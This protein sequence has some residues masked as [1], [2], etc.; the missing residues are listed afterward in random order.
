M[1][2]RNFLLFLVICSIS[3]N[4]L[5]AWTNSDSNWKLCYEENEIKKPNHNEKLNSYDP[6]QSGESNVDAVCKDIEVFLDINGEASI[7]PDMV[8]NGSTS[9]TNQNLSLSISTFNC[10]NLGQNLVTL[11]VSCDEGDDS[12]QATVDVIDNVFPL[13]EC[14]SH[15][16]FVDNTGFV[17]VDYMD[18]ISN[19]IDNCQNAV[20]SLSKD[21]LFCSDQSSSTITVTGTD[22]GGASSCMSTVIIKD[23]VKPDAFCKDTVFVSLGA[24]GLFTLDEV[25]V[26]D[27]STDNCS[28]TS[29]SLSIYELNCNDLGFSSQTMTVVDNSIPANSDICDFTLS[30]SNGSVPQMVCSNATVSLSQDGDLTVDPSLV[31]GGSTV[32]CGAIS[33]SLDQEQFGC[34]NLGPNLVVLT[35]E[36]SAGSTSSTCNAVITV[37][38]N[39]SPNL[40]CYANVTVDLGED[41]NLLLQAEDLIESI[42]DNCSGSFVFDLD[43]DSFDCTDLGNTFSIELVALDDENNSAICTSTVSID[44]NSPPML[45][46]NNMVATITSEEGVSILSADLVGTISDNCD[47]DPIISPV[48]FDFTCS[49]TN[50]N[51]V[52]ITATDNNGNVSTCSSVININVADAPNAECKPNLTVELDSDGEG[53]ISVPEVNDGSSVLCQIP[54]MTLDQDIFTC[55][56]LLNSPVSVTLIVSNS[57]G[58]TDECQTLVTVIDLEEPEVTCKPGLQEVE[59]DASGVASGSYNEF[60]DSVN[61]NCGDVNL[62]VET[63][64][65]QCTDGFIPYNIFVEDASNNSNSCTTLIQVVDNLLPTAV[66]NSVTVSLNSVGLGT[67]QG[68]DLTAGSFDNCSV[69][70]S[71]DAFTFDCGDVGQDVPVD[72]TVFDGSGNV[73]LPCTAMVTV[74]D[75]HI[76]T[77]ICNEDVEIFVD[78]NNLAVLDPVSL[79]NNSYDNCSSADLSFSVSQTNFNCDFLGNNEVTLYVTDPSNNVDTCNATI[80]VSDNSNPIAQCLDTTF[81]ALNA[82]GNLELVLSDIFSGS[83]FS[84]SGFNHSIFP[85]SFDCTHVGIVQEVTLSIIGSE[86]STAVCNV[87]IQDLTPPTF[88][89]LDVEVVLSSSAD[90]IIEPEA[91]I[92]NGSDVCTGTEIYFNISPLVVNCDNIGETVFEL[93]VIDGNLNVDSCEVSITVEN[94]TLPNAICKATHEVFLDEEGDASIEIDD[95]NNGS[96][97]LCGNILPTTGAVL[98][99]TQF[100]CDD[101]DVDEVTLFISD[102][103]GNVDSCTTIILVSDTIPPEIQDSFNDTIVFTISGENEILS[104]NIYDINPIDN[105]PILGTKIRRINDPM[106]LMDFSTGITFYGNEQDDVYP[107]ELQILDQS[108][109]ALVVPVYVQ[110]INTVSTS[111]LPKIIQ[112]AKIRPNPFTES[113]L[114]EFTLSERSSTQINVYN[115]TGGLVYSQDFNLNEGDHGIPIDLRN[116]P[117]GAYF[118]EIQ[119]KKHKQVLRL[120]KIN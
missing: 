13:F 14:K 74:E 115:A 81:V 75:N 116:Y 112:E 93:A 58:T 106:G 39:T 9:C 51:I 107:C 57:A 3:T 5:L 63:Y 120:L 85:F 87:V 72:V 83:S 33:F 15:T 45:T 24:D 89:C 78:A 118:C 95:I 100:N 7:T 50:T 77:A 109:N 55:A 2:F 46:C 47:L 37:V 26:N 25:M 54:G 82:D 91:F 43:Q 110:L 98:N 101:I 66:C 104:S 19:E 8:D 92:T 71:N 49:D 40:N 53:S 17:V 29:Y 69:N 99:K 32:A 48:A 94:Q 111:E 119:T 10:V 68:D 56:D 18:L 67:V 117:S 4:H 103:F 41:G 86:T 84:C 11:F 96:S 23:T 70:G 113:T 30:V 20:Y 44:D 114:V 36:L 35:G 42:D 97:D 80:L 65:Y 27:G 1:N 12:C 62:V 61:D 108:L 76:P 105:C 79:N 31:D 64:S 60:I 28:I 52:D 102:N 6:I 90:T 34:D 16:Y 88:D 59:L 73:S 38:D 22:P 21:T